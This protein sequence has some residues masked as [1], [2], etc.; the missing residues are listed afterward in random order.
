LADDEPAISVIVIARDDEAIIE[1]AIAAIVSQELAEPFE[2]ILVT[3]GTDRTAAIVRAGFPGVT[4]VELDH[5]A[6]PGEA[7]NAGLRVARGRYVTFPGSHIELLP[8]SLA[9]RLAAHH[10]GWPMVTETMLNGTRTW[11]G[12]ASYFLDNATV[13][14]DRGSFVFES[15]PLRC[16]YRRDLLSELGGFPEDMR[17]GEDTV[18]NDELFGRGYGAYRE[19]AA[20]AY[21]HSPCRRPARLLRHHWQRGRGMGRILADAHAVGRVSGRRLARYLVRALPGRLRSIHR[22]V[23]MWGGDLRGRYRRALPLV[24]AGAVASWAGCAYELSRQLRR[25]TRTPP[26]AVPAGETRSPAGREPR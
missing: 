4:V 15:A 6:L 26:L 20:E 17:T 25:P 23:R 21:H 7:R 10:A 3:S 2:V 5:P 13:L 19:R 16:S 24:V 22:R 11:A 8:G 14:P 1:R 12:W 18:V 9:A